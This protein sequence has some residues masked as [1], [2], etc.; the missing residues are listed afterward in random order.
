MRQHRFDPF[1]F[2]FGALFLT[3]GATFLFGR[4]QVGDVHAARLWPA[5]LAVIGVT[6]AFS[7]VARVLRPASERVSAADDLT[8][9]LPTEPA[10]EAPAEGDEPSV[11]IE[12]SVD[13]EPVE[14]GNDQPGP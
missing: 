3:V 13:V 6:L 10:E 8:E 12:P 2:V 4:A 1:S 11:D 7:A 9:V 14:D 5:A